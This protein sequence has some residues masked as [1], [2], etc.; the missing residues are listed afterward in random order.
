MMKRRSQDHIDENGEAQYSD[1][2]PRKRIKAD[3]Q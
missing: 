3:T 1:E 2:S